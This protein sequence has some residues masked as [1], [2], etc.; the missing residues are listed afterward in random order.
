MEMKMEM[1]GKRRKQRKEKKRKVGSRDGVR[2]ER[3]SSRVD[4]YAVLSS[5]PLAL[6]KRTGPRSP[7]P[8]SPKHRSPP[9]KL[10]GYA[11]TPLLFLSPKALDVTHDR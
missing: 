3:K 7:A 4:L 11:C 6:P 9:S 2:K 10:A 5:D 1:E 8:K